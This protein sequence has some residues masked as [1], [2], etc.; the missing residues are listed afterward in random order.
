MRLSKLLPTLALAAGLGAG[1][2]LADGGTLKIGRDQDSNT[3]DPIYTIENADIWV[4]NNMNAKLVRVADD[5]SGVAPA[6]AKSWDISD[7]KTT[8]TFHLREGLKFS[9]GDPLTA[10]DV[11]FSLERLRDEKESVLRS[12][13]QVVEDVKAPDLRTVVIELEHPSAPFMSALAVFSASIVPEDVVKER[14]ENFG[15]NPVGAGAFRLKEWERGNRIVLER[16][17]HYY[18]DGQPK[19]DEVHWMVEANDNTRLLK[20]QAGEIDAAIGVPFSRIEGLKNNANIKVKL[21]PSSREDHLLMN[22]EHAPLGKLKVRRAL[23]HAI[24]R[25]AI[26]DAVLFGYGEVATSFVPEGQMF[27]NPDVPTYEYDPEKARQLLD[28]AGVENPTLDLIVAA[29]NSTREQTAVLLQ[30]MLGKVGINVNI[31]KQEPGQTWDTIVQGDYDLSIN[32]WTNDII[33]PDQKATFSV[34]GENDA[35]SYYT[36]YHNPE[37]ADLVEKGRTVLDTE[38]RK[39]IYF[40]IQEMVK[41]DAH[42]ID[43]YYSPFR[44]AMR[45]N[46]EN[47]NQTPMGR[48]TLETTTVNQ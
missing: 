25:Q 17:P 19:L 29:G 34:Y 22:H 12:M 7:D 42:W 44:N 3:L 46:V 47:F 11:E 20:L 26:V 24:D 27:H 43:L 23:Y 4:L 35:Q 36:R 30:N 21:E 14:G 16:N 39:D 32:Y 38:E 37:V 41:K 31:V 33:D 8:Y 5:M 45:T 10:S 6:L 13:F 15:T 40:R 18:K 48:F 2:A 1:P 28:E 9:N